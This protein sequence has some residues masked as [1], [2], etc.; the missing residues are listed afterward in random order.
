M[1]ASFPDYH[2]AR[3]ASQDAAS[4]HTHDSLYDP[5]P[6]PTTYQHPA[7]RGRPEYDDHPPGDEPPPYSGPGVPNEGMDKDGA[8]P[9][10]PDIVTDRGLLS[11]PRQRQASLGIL[12]HPQPANM[13]ASPQRSS[14][15]MGAD[16]LRRQ[17]LEVEV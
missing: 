12:Q 1:N 14:A 6:P 9:R 8:P 10:P 5:P 11:S 3:P 15:D 2:M 13:A 4:N 16:I 7:H 17:L